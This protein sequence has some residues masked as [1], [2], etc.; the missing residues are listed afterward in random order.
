MPDQNDVTS[1]SSTDN[2]KSSVTQES[3]PAT[4]VSAESSTATT[5]TTETTPE[6]TGEAKEGEVA[7]DVKKPQT[8]LEAVKAAIQTDKKPVEV[9]AKPVEQEA[10]SESSTDAE[11]SEKDFANEPFAKHPR[12][13]QLLDQRNQYLK[14]LDAIEPLAKDYIEYQRFIREEAGLSEE[15]FTGLIQLS[16]LSKNDPKTLYGVLKPFVDQLALQTGDAM[17]PDLQER[18]D[19]GALSEE[20]AKEIAQARAQANLNGRKAEQTTQTLV[21]TREQQQAESVKKFTDAIRVSVNAEEAQWKKSDPDY[22]RKQKVI[23][24]RV[25]TKLR[26]AN[27]TSVADAVKIA[28]DAKAEIDK[29]LGIVPQKKSVVVTG[30]NAVRSAATPKTSLEAAR[31]ALSRGR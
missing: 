7:Q 20:A 3:Q 17:P 24:D 11:L 31:Q 19:A 29:E 16:W 9:E 4:D 25:M 14:R 18:V 15:E 5:E 28:R 21:K 12:F 23:R 8:L 30:G 6:A 1:E 22:N 2:E 26:E 10:Q 13:K 27:I